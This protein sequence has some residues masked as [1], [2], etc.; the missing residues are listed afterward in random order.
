M[1]AKLGGVA[2]ECNRLESAFFLD[3]KNPIIRLVLLAL[4]TLSTLRASADFTITKCDEASIREALA[5]GPIIRFSCDGAITL[6]N[7][8]TISDEIVFDASGHAVTI[9]GE[10][11]VRVF[12]VNTGVN[13]TLINLTVANGFS[14]NA[15]GGI[16]NDGGK[17]SLINC[18]LSSNRAVGSSK[19]LVTASQGLP[20]DKASG[21]AVYNSGA[22]FAT[23]TTFTSNSAVGGS[24][25]PATG[26]FGD[27]GDASG[28]AIYNLGTVSLASCNFKS[29]DV[30]GGQGGNNI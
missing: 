10:Q 15:G 24:G 17:L 22:L 1:C 27:G 16:Y 19:D 29:N 12:Q 23:N 2:P 3:R 13:L 25:G 4:T 6:T 18:T 8:L 7:H 5:N 11:K 30:T 14:T 21:G 20:G 9:S 28:G 26:N